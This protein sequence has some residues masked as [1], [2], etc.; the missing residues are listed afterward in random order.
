MTVSFTKR[1]LTENY[2]ITIGPKE[3]VFSEGCPTKGYAFKLIGEVSKELTLNSALTTNKVQLL[4]IKED[5]EFEIPTSCTF[6]VVKS[7]LI[8]E[9]NCRT[10]TSIPNG[11]VTIKELNN[12]EITDNIFISIDKGTNYATFKLGYSYLGINY[13]QI[14]KKKEIKEWPISFDINYM[15]KLKQ[16]SQVIVKA[17]E[18]LLKNCTIKDDYYGLKCYVDQNTLIG[19][20]KK[21]NNY[22][23]YKIT[24]T[25][26]C[27]QTEETDMSI[28]VS[29]A[30]NIKIRYLLHL[31]LVGLVLL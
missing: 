31:S 30:F 29:K 14:I 28:R 21:P 26:V 4:S 16:D 12:A 25:N 24:V 15:T 22:I 10:T 27:L 8:I 6:P 2:L 17:G 1:I 23:Y 5:K 11:S 9:I 18:H 3:T 19:D 7:S 20:K 13:D